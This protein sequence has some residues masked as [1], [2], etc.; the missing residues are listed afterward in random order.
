[1]GERG[2]V[3]TIINQEYPNAGSFLKCCS[4]AFNFVQVDLPAKDFYFITSFQKIHP[5]QP[6]FFDQIF[7]GLHMVDHKTY[8]FLF[9]R[10]FHSCNPI[11]LFEYDV[12]FS[13]NYFMIKLFTTLKIGIDC[14][15]TNSGGLCKVVHGYIVGTFVGKF[16]AGSSKNGMTGRV[17]QDINCTK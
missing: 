17:S 16:N 6:I 10:Y 14:S 8:D 2:S 12:I 5:K 1:M 11:E 13:F 9:W 3:F 4:E 15:S 7:Y